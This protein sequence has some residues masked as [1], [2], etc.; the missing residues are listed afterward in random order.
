MLAL[1]GHQVPCQWMRSRMDLQSITSCSSK[2]PSCSV[3]K[4]QLTSS[5]STSLLPFSARCFCNTQYL[6]HFSSDNK[7]ANQHVILIVRASRSLW[8]YGRT[9]SNLLPSLNSERSFSTKSYRMPMGLKNRTYLSSMDCLEG[10]S[11]GW[12]CPRM[13]YTVPMSPFPF[14]NQNH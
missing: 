12:K 8:T 10:R 14:L 9:R 11:S 13:Q 1:R 5:S 3:L 4:V 2:S 7:L 6:L